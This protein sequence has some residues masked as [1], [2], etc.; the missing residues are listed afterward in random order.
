NKI[1]NTLG[2][3]SYRP[4]ALHLLHRAYDS[5]GIYSSLAALSLLAY[6]TSLALFGHHAL[7]P[8]SLRLL[9]AHDILENMKKKYP[10]GKIWR[11]MEGKLNKMERNNR[12]GVEVLRDARRTIRKE[13]HSIPV[14]NGVGG[15]ANGNN[16]SAKREKVFGEL[17]Q[18]QAL[19]VYEMGWGQIFLG[20]YFQASETFFRLETMN[21]WS[22]AFYHYIAT[23]CMFADE[24]YGK[25]ALEF[26]QIPAMLHRRKSGTRL[27]PNEAFADRKIRVWRDKARQLDGLP[28]RRGRR[29]SQSEDEGL[30][31]RRESFDS[32]STNASSTSV[33]DGERLRQV[34]VVNPLWELVYLWNGIPQLGVNVLR[35]MCTSLERTIETHTP[36]IASTSSFASSV[37]SSSLI[38]ESAASF[39][40]S[41]PSPV[42]AIN[43]L[44][45][46]SELALL[47]L[48]YG[49]TVRELGEHSLA[50]RSLH[51]VLD[52]GPRITEDRWVIPYALYEM[53]VLCCMVSGMGG[54][55]VAL[56]TPSLMGARRDQKIKEAKE[57][58]KKAAEWNNGGGV[59]TD[60]ESGNGKHAN[61]NGGPAGSTG[62]YDF[63]GRLHMRCQLLEERL[64][65]EFIVTLIHTVPVSGTNMASVQKTPVTMYCHHI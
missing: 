56:S 64:T 16:G 19:A 49:T 58:L 59:A 62:D 22:R 12:K 26:L 28:P 39:S 33:L 5:S 4:F 1:L 55:A 53:A 6:Y 43:V 13:K 65:E 60:R 40:S 44:C 57:F 50:E 10:R 61:G 51:I 32:N 46:T 11:L 31:R 36:I 20:D 42:S 38:S 48:L 45:S 8:S 27:M 9:D 37:T 41:P 29:T 2:F 47:H 52:L 3:T 25:A 23:C 17:A 15:S 21:N 14:G 63:D 24:E 35:T 18:L 34:V 54:E 30:G 7:L